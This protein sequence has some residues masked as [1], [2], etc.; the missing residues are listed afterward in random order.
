[1]AASLTS[2]W[3][4]AGRLGRLVAGLHGVK[5]LGAHR[6]FLE[7]KLVALIVRRGLGQLGPGLGRP[8]LGLVH[9]GLELRRRQGHQGVSRL[10]PGAGLHPD[11]RHPAGDLGRHLGQALADHRPQDLQL[12]GNLGFLDDQDPALRRRACERRQPRGDLAEVE[13]PRQ[14]GHEQDAPHHQGA[15]SDD[16]FFV[17][18]GFFVQRPLREGAGARSPSPPSNSLPTP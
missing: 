9:P 8:A 7:E 14:P 6:A 3:D 15:Q 2:A 1:M 12:P 10:D 5:L 13:Q 4:W 17:C 18:H 11:F 16:F